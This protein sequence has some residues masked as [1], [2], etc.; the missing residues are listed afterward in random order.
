VIREG[1]VVLDDQSGAL[2][3]IRRGDSAVDLDGHGSV[4]LL[5]VPALDDGS[6]GDTLD[7]VSEVSGGDLAC[8]R[9]VHDNIED[10]IGVSCTGPGGRGISA[11]GEVH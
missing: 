11:R 10:L 5:E 9:V 4:D 8:A 1:L 2:V 6:A 7:D 3:C